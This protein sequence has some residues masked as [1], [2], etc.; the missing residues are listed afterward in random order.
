MPLYG[1]GSR[2][3]GGPNSAGA[4]TQPAGLANP[5][6]SLAGSQPMPQRRICTARVLG[7]AELAFFRFT[8][9]VSSASTWVV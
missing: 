6:D 4:G 1:A 8:S 3:G 5:V 9:S 2:R 7:M